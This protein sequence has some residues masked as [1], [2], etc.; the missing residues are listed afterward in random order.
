LSYDRLMRKSPPP[1]QLIDLMREAIERCA[2]D[3]SGL[4]VLTEAASGAYAVTSVLAAL[5]GARRVVALARDTRYGTVAEVAREV[6]SL[7]RSTNVAE[8][9]EIVTEKTRAIVADADIITNSGHLRP[10]DREMIGWMKPTAVIPLMYEAWE[11]RAADID[12]AACAARGIAVAGTNERHPAVEVFS[13]LG[14][15]AERL[16]ADAGIALRGCRIVVLSDNAFRDFIVRHFI[17]AGAVAEAAQSLN[18]IS[19]LPCDTLL[20]AMTPNSWPIIGSHEAEIIATR[21][22]G[23]LVAQ[24]WGDID[25]EAL[26]QCGMRF[27]PIEAPA[28]GHQSIMLSTVGP[29]PIVRLQAGGLKVGEVM[30]NAR[31]MGLEPVAAAV[32]S[33]FGQAVT[34]AEARKKFDS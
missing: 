18:D 6:A 30:A 20:V 17:E 15:V 19:M 29:E 27:W 14:P 34:L 32:T 1:E 2:L 25:R 28:P 24:F 7:A 9:I 3:L 12:V 31:L 8:R 4:S 33:G 16:L 26:T 5:S 10:I 22:P 23:A 11:L 13:F 21:C